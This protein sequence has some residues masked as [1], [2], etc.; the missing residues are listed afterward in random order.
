MNA[1]TRFLYFKVKPLLFHRE[2][3]ILFEHKTTIYQSSPATITKVTLEN[4]KDV[5]DFEKEH[6]LTYFYTF[7]QH[8]DAG[9]YAYINNKCI[10][11]SWVKSNQQSIYFHML[12]K[13]TLK[14]NEC[15]IHYCATAKEQRGKNIYP[16][17]LS[18]IVEDY[19]GYRILIT[20]DHNNH[21]SIRG[22]EKAGFQP[23]Q[24]LI[25][26]HYFGIPFIKLNAIQSGNAD[27]RLQKSV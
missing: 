5:L 25:V 13:Y 8:K 2:A 11:R 21:A 26:T 16:H 1:I 22:V 7:L 20:V 18:K 9:Y 19:P 12:F 23:I 3:I 6:Y 14:K 24:E 10:H 15:F 4:I 27:V 17:V